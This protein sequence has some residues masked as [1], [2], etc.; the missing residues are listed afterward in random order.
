MSASPL[1]KSLRRLRPIILAVLFFT[2]ILP[3]IGHQILMRNYYGATETEI[4]NSTNIKCEDKIYSRDGR[5]LGVYSY[6]VIIQRG[7]LWN[8]ESYYKKSDAGSKKNDVEFINLEVR[9][10]YIFSIADMIDSAELIT[11]EYIRIFSKT[12]PISSLTPKEIYFE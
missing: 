11:G 1:R 5:F 10:P 4:L 3:E 2:W 8:S 6:R 12:Y 7:C 9:K